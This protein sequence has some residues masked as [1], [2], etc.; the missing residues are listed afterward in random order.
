VGFSPGSP[1]R[2][3][4]CHR[5]VHRVILLLCCFARLIAGATDIGV[6]TGG[7]CL[8]VLAGFRG[9]VA[10]CRGGGSGSTRCS[11]PEMRCDARALD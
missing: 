1:G 8:A 7:G 6:D 3:G 10:G 9:L 11:L 2:N 4:D 5:N